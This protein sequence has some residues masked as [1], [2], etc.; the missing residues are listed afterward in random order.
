MLVSNNV[1]PLVPR[2][3][4]ERK[5]IDIYKIWSHKLLVIWNNHFG[6]VNFDTKIIWANH[7]LGW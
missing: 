5:R 1:I 6:T 4:W 3:K 2:W 7:G